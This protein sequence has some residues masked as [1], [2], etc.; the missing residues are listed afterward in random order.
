MAEA[1]CAEGYCREFSRYTNVTVEGL[2]VGPYEA[3]Y[4]RRR[5]KNGKSVL[6][7]IERG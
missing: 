2:A 3:R 6:G 7:R 1:S 5:D 4:Q